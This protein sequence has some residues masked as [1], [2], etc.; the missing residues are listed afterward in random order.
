MPRHV[1][2]KAVHNREVNFALAEFAEK[3]FAISLDASIWAL[4]IRSARIFDCLSAQTL[5]S[6]RP[7]A[8][9]ITN[10]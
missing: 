5:F 1:M 2:T 4:E 10:E 3:A 6:S 8:Y 7:I 9:D